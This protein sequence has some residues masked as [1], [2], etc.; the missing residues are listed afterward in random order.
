MFGCKAWVLRDIINKYYE[1]L[2]LMRQIHDPIRNQN[3]NW[4]IRTNEE[5]HL[6]IKHADIV[7][8]LPNLKSLILQ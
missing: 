6:L 8:Y 3:G 1:C 5:I 4:R 2:K 7:I